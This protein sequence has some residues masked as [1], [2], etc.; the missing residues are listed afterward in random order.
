VLLTVG[1]VIFTIDAYDVPVSP[2]IKLN[3]R[4]LLTVI[5][6]SVECEAVVVVS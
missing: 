5:I 3:V 2:E 4:A 1:N 6:I